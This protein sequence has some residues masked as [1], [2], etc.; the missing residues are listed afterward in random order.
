MYH[1]NIVYML[2]IHLYPSHIGQVLSAVR[3]DVLYLA[4]IQ[5]TLAVPEVVDTENWVTSNLPFLLDSN[6]IAKMQS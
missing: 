4:S 2:N 3:L 1:S 5:I 6:C